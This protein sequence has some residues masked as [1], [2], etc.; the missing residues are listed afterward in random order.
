MNPMTEVVLRSGG[1]L[2]NVRLDP[3]NEH[4]NKDITDQAICY[5]FSNLE[6]DSDITLR[7]VFLLLN[8]NLD[9]YSVIFGNWTEEY[10]KEGLL[11]PQIKFKS[12]MR[13]ELSYY[14]IND[15]YDLSGNLMPD[16]HGFEL[17]DAGK[18]II[19][20]VETLSANLLASLPLSLNTTGVISDIT[21]GEEL[22]VI[23]YRNIFCEF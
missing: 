23:N 8:S 19:V 1:K 7:D 21:G 18:E 13:L 16:L 14:I 20:G 10:V 5:L 15:N 9:L 4:H 22:E 12:K 3:K 2:F 6:L 17:N 11:E